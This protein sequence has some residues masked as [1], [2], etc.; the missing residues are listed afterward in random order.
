MFDPLYHMLLED[1]E[2]LTSLDGPSGFEDEVREYLKDR[3]SG[4][5]EV[6]VD[7]IGNLIA[8][9]QSS[10]RPRVLVCA[11]MDEVG[12][13]V[14][15][16]DDNGFIK[17]TP[18]GGWDDRIVLGMPVRI[19]GKEKILGVFSTIPPHI[20]K[21]EEAS[22][23]M[24][25]EECFIDTGLSKKELDEQGVTI[26]S[27][28]VP[29]SQF[30]K[31]KNV[32]MAKALDDRV[33]CSLLLELAQIA[34]SLD[35][36]LIIGATVQEEVGTRG[37]KVLANQEEPD[38]AI[39]LECT[40]AADLPNVEISRRPTSLRNGVA[41]TL[42]DKTI[43]SNKRLFDKALLIAKELGIMYQIKRPAYGGTDAGAIHL[44]GRGIP[45]LV[46]SCPAR[47][48]HSN[49]S[50]TTKENIETMKKLVLS[51]LENISDLISE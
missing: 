3:L 1:L 5:L 20:L 6:K 25:I 46:I 50:L 37:A 13:M 51:L 14:Q 31:Q 35:Y 41:I 11:H 47:Y 38:I 27:F 34:N 30:I 19:L 28:V 33:G 15:D 29:Y 36:E 32:I 17:V 26:G 23:V 42:M 24:K 4:K 44:S 40:T 21:P 39:I 8:R 43:I 22:R 16:I 10:K 2:K 12:F 18:I 45:S 7:R 9:N 49:L 48:I